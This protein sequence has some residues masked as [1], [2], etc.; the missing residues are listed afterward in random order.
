MNRL[1]GGLHSPRAM[2]YGFWSVNR[3][4]HP[5]AVPPFALAFSTTALYGHALA[6][7]DEEGVVTVLDTRRSLVDQTHAA[8]TST[9]PV[10][11]FVAH[12]NAIFDIIWMPGDKE[13]AT[14]SGDG[15]VRV[16]DIDTMYRRALLRGHSGSAKAIR[17]LPTM[18]NVLM[19]TGRDGNVRAFD[20]RVPSVTDHDSREQYH[21]PVFTI[22]QPHAP[23]PPSNAIS[24]GG[25]GS[26]KRRRVAAPK[27]R[28]SHG[29][30]VT[31]LAF[32]PGQDS[33]LYTAGAA[34]G[35]VKLW[36]LRALGAV[37]GKDVASARCV[38]KITPCIEPRRNGIPTARRTHG[39]AHIDVDD[40]GQN[41]L[42]ASTD[43]SIYLYN[44]RNMS[45]GHTRVLTGHTA[46][47]FYIRARF[48]PDGTHVLSGSADAKAYVWD[49][50]GRAHS[51]T[52]QPVLAL[53]GHSGGEASAV[54]WCRRDPL[55]LATCADDATAR[56]WTVK[57]GRRPAPPKRGDGES[58]V[59]E[60]E[61]ECT[62]R[63]V[64]PKV[65]E[66]MPMRIS[67][68]TTPT[69]FRN[70]DIRNYLRKRD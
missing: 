10:S 31:S 49:I 8:T 70:A 1:L 23:P 33:L 26:R 36:D 62:A 55:K 24:C 18:P 14:A 46:T 42:V 17:V 3:A 12:D 68:T 44:A 28:S 54:D 11:R 16:F 45:L 66:V 50:S 32:L 5:V 43:S 48:S 20:L 2:E 67:P 6:A 60:D 40:Q 35:C 58:D 41:L 53:D 52:V 21:A 37:G 27:P 13:V 47:S 57:A 61:D 34:D 29:A 30:S 38:S 69:K 59:E 64:R 39:V 19:S 15:T 25:G 9:S 65:R 63:L 7:A 56:V 22:D 4:G 51:G